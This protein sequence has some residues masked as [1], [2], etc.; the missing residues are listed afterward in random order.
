MLYPVAQVTAVSPKTNTTTA[1]RLGAFRREH[2][3]VVLYDTP[4]VVGP[5]S[6]HGARHEQRVRSAWGTAA[7]TDL[8]LFLVDAQRQVALHV[9]A[10]V[11]RLWV[12][13]PSGRLGP[14]FW[15][16]YPLVG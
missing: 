4:G 11:L 6:L 7:G 1:A 16:V 13:M 8:L 2:T 9:F 5:A 3:Q 12:V 10:A 15:S 14:T